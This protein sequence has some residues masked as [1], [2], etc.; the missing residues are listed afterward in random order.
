MIEDSKSVIIS[1]RSYRKLFASSLPFVLQFV[2]IALPLSLVVFFFY[3]EITKQMCL[4]TKAIIAPSFQPDTIQIA[5]YPHI[6]GDAYFISLPGRFPSVLFSLINALVSLVFLALLSNIHRMKPLVIFGVV[7][8]SITLISSLFFIFVSEVFPY[9]ASDYSDLYIIQQIS[10]WFFVPIIMGLSALPL[11]SSL[12]SKIVTMLATC[13]YSLIFGT[14]RYIVFLFIVGKISM[15]YMALLFFVFGPLLDFL[16]I[17]AIYSVY[18][19][20]L[21]IKIKGDFTL[22]KWSY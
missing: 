15:L 18:T 6:F 4:T 1:H 12:L 5:S 21:A 17:V 14:I 19:T 13:V 22:W 11:P 16:Y 9:Q 8:S 2:F 7:V 20:R 3:P 10:I